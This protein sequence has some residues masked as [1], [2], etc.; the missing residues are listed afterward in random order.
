MAVAGDLA[1]LLPLIRK[2]L[3]F[4]YFTDAE[5][6]RMLGLSDLLRLPAGEKLFSQGDDSLAVYAL[7][8]G[9]VDLSFRKASGTRVS[10][11]AVSAGEVFGEAG[12]FMTVKRTAD[13]LV[14]VDSALLKIDRKNMMTFIK[15][16]PVG[17]NKLLMLM[18]YGLLSKLREANQMLSLENPG[19][20]EMDS[21]DPLFQDFMNET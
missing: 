11:S 14:A 4:S 9:Q 18:I 2:I 8:Q 6:T 5:L 3:I 13:A 1:A 20:I 10:V 15:E 16:H 17:G 21:I 12:V 19:A 7:I